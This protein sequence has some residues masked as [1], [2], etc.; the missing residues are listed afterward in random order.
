MELFL[1]EDCDTLATVEVFSD[2]LKIAQCNC[3]RSTLFN[4]SNLFNTR[5]AD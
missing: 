4:P 5:E 1:C 2:E 3:V